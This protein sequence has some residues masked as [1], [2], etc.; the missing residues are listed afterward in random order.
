MTWRI[1]SRWNRGFTLLE[2]IIAIALFAIIG[3]AVAGTMGQMTKL[4]KKIKLKETTVMS[5]QVALDRIERDLQMAF[6]EKV[7]HSPSFFKASNVGAGPEATF[8]F[9]DS[10][11]KTLFEQRTPGL[12]FAHYFTERDDNGTVKILRATAPSYVGENIKNEPGRLLA[13]GVLEWT[14][15][16]YDAQ[17]DL[18]HSDWDTSA[19]QTLNTFPKAVR[20]TIKTVDINLPKE[21]WK[22]KALILSTEFLVLNESEIKR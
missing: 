8:S 22:D 7:L 16:Y 10:D 5:G 18:W 6:N 17:N 9:L 3:A 12:L 20:V 2:V 15:E 19:A 21:D 14:L 4:T 1:E 13:T 11:I